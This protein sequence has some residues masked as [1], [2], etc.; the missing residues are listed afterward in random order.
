MAITAKVVRMPGLMVEVM[1]EDDA[2]IADALA[3]ASITLS[4]GESLKMNAMPASTTDTVVQGAA[5]VVSQAAK[6]A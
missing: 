1:L 5:I 4:S 2:T 6:G 3:A